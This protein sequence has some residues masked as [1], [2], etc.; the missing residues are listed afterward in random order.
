[1]KTLNTRNGHEGGAKVL[2]LRSHES[3]GGA[4]VTV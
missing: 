1:M 4:G 3:A 2:G